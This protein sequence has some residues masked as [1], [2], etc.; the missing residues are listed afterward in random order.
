MQKLLFVINQLF[1]GGAETSLVAILKN[2]PPE[3]FAVDLVVYDHKTNVE[4]IS[5]IPEI[6]PHVKTCISTGNV[7]D[8]DE[9]GFFRR[10]TPEVLNFVSRKK[11]DL[12]L[13]FGE[14]FSTELVMKYTKAARKA[15]WLHSDISQSVLVNLED[16]FKYDHITDFY[17]CVSNVFAG[18]I[19]SKFPFL[20]GRTPVVHN[21]SDIEYLLRMAEEPVEVFD[22]NDP[23]RRLLSVGNFRPEKNY[24]RAIHAAAIVKKRGVKFRWYCAGAFSHETTYTEALALIRELGLEEEFV[25][26]GPQRN[27]YKLMKNVSALVS[28][29]DYESWSMVISEAKAIGL[30]VIATNTDGAAEQLHHE[31]DSLICDFTPEDLAE[32]LYTYLTDPELEIRFRES[33]ANNTAKVRIAEELQTLLSQPVRKADM[34]FVIDSVN[35]NGGA[36]IATANLMKRL[37]RNGYHID[38]FSGTIP[39]LEARNKFA[40]LRITHM[41]LTECSIWE[42]VP[43]RKCLL[44]PEFTLKQKFYKL[45]L[46]V[47]KRLFPA[48]IPWFN[49]SR[50]LLSAFFSHYPR[51]CVMSEG[52]EYRKE[53]SVASV[54]LKIQMIHTNYKQWRDFSD[55]TRSITASDRELYKSVDS[56]LLV[57]EKSRE[58]FAEI[59]PEYN[60]KTHAVL[61]I[62]ECQR[63]ISPLPKRTNDPLQLLTVARLEAEK[64]IPRMISL[65]ASL[66]NAGIRFEW[67][68][69]GYSSAIEDFRKQ[70]V[71]DQVDDVFHLCG[72]SNQLDEAFEKADLFCLFSHYEGL[73]NTVFESLIKGV[74]VIATAVGGIPE[75][76]E[77]GKSGFL[78]EDD[79]QKIFQK[80]LE[81]SSNPEQLVKAREFLEDYK[82]DNDKILRD[83]IA[84]FK[85]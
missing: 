64:D 74:P 85:L 12:A 8:Y 51:V 24:R 58:S 52:S 7:A 3:K 33:L 53:V 57:S 14:W 59:F 29:S 31:V 28:S 66:K 55:Y 22:C 21:V 41:N 2:L 72:Y 11:Y 34:L 82:Y 60:G 50:R 71:E 83:Y 39:T 54:P 48:S 36:H 18:N 78:V 44:S 37:H 68:V 17:I 61:N 45:R 62:I 10:Y 80:L 40:P 42:N 79:E 73:P 38:I 63:N 26:L 19:V 81:L 30:P 35:Y 23:V 76:L 27:P 46:A 77:D 84:H 16:I 5:L 1:K 4:S 56:I 32:K 65:A 25:L 20:E 70:C 75:Q 69:Y 43:F 49:S 6:P 13:S 47:M 67:N 9:N 15:V